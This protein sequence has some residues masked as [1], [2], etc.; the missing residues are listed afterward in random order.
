MNTRLTIALLLSAFFSLS[1][2]NEHGSNNQSV[3]LNDTDTAYSGPKYNDHIRFTNSRTPEQERQGFKLPEGF[4]INL[5]ASEPD[6]GKPINFNFDAKGRMWVTQSFEYPFPAVPGKGRDRVT[7]LE[8]TDGD[9]KADKFTHFDD[10]LN[11]PIGIMPIKGGAVAYSIP[12]VIRFDDANDDGKPETSRKL[13]GPFETRDTHGMVNNFVTGYDGWIHACH[14]FTNHS[15]VAGA[16]G[17]SVHLIS[18]NTIRFRPDGSRVEHETAGRINPFGLVY[19]ELG[20]LYSTDCH[21][22]P[23]YQMIRGG[24]YSQWGKDEGMGFAP[25]MK[26]FDNEATALAGLAYYA[27]VKFPEKYRKSLY[28]GDVVTSRVYRN[29][30]M[31]KG[32]SPV[33]KKEEDFIKSLDPWFRPVAVQMGPDGAIYIADFYNSIIGHYEVPL[34][35][36]KRDKIRGRIWRVTYKGVADKKKDWTK[37]GID[38]LFRALD[39][40]NLRVRMTAGDQLVDRIGTQAIEPIKAL[41]SKKDV[42]QTEYVQGLWALQRLD[43]L[44]EDIATKA[45]TSADPVVRLHALRALAEQRDTSKTLYPLIVR[46]LQDTSSHV[47]RAAVELMGRY[48]DMKTVETLIA[49]RKHIA[50]EDTHLIYTTRLVLRNLLRHEF[51]MKD[52]ASR[53]WTNE[54]AEVL[55]TVLP[56]VENPASGIFL[57]NYLNSKGL[58]SGQLPNAFKHITRFVPAHQ[59]DA[60]IHMAKIQAEKYPQIEYKIYQQ[61]QEGLIRRAAKPSPQMDLWGKTLMATLLHQKIDL[62]SRANPEVLA[63]QQFAI[64]LAGNYKD[65]KQYPALMKI[66]EDTSAIQDIRTTAL[67]AVLKIHPEQ[68]N[69]IAEKFLQDTSV[70]TDFKRAVVT[71]MSEYP[72][73]SVSLTLAKVR[74]APPDVQWWIIMALGSSTFGND[75]LFDKVKKGELLPRQIAEPKIEERILLNTS[76]AQQ[77]IYLKLT[78]NLSTVDKEKQQ[79]I[80][81]RISAFNDLQPK[82]SPDLGHT[83]FTKNCTPCHNIKGEGG[84]IGPQLDGV[85]KWGVTSL[86]EKILD[87]NRSVSENFRNFTLKLKDGKTLSGLYRRDEGQALIFV[88]M[89]GKEFTVAK[90]DI[91]QKIPSP[92]TLMPDQFRNTIP[93]K[94]FNALIAFL[95]TQKN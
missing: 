65:Q 40:D 46:S 27:D 14:G 5:Y 94:D 56:G 33:G 79:L 19:D 85:G 15:N 2:C 77:K 66:F 74:N 42:T 22:S 90:K 59:L 60:V 47:R 62:S 28:I 55:S 86:M 25:D 69:A 4:E 6:I 73:R 82:P 31:F 21:T 20:Y 93:E 3:S 52:A 63:R 17:D 87:P 89:S 8:D 84:H 91:A 26:P 39:A 49:F 35:H 23:L 72:S 10:T 54:D 11:I 37:A 83:V 61:V 1:A 18:G 68:N 51:L 30:F 41:I 95:L 9:G 88:D 53:Q 58:A 44:T 12:N 16:D 64:A 57:F 7:I 43:A 45:A 76:P 70:T 81:G 29:T 50:L 78:A 13:L 34:Y 67:R 36:P 24:D 92:Y 32:S 38:E 75:L 80:D 48:P 71:V